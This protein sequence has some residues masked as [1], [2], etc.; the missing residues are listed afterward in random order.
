MGG[1]MA[2]TRFTIQFSRTDPAHMRV[3]EIL[4]RQGRRS[5][6]QYIVN[7]VL[8]YENCGETPNM[9]RA[10]ELDIKVIEAV[11]N[12]ILRDKEENGENKT[13]G[14]TAS[15]EVNKPIPDTDDIIFDDVWETLGEEGFNAVT[16]ALDMF[17]KK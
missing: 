17:R 1:K 14:V 6:A 16:G 2:E 5:K 15:G 9:Q 10:S 8:H 12:R 7:A 3:A 4:N 11:V 13:N